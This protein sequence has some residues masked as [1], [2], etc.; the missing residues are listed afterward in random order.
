M[1][2]PP[3][4]RAADVSGGLKV[5]LTLLCVGIFRWYMK[6]QP[7]LAVG[8]GLIAGI[9][10]SQ[11]IPPRKPARYLLLWIAGAAVLAIVMAL[12]PHSGW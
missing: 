1:E 5:A 11:A 8:L 4:P 2:A 9:L 6:S 12:F 7:S 3:K 10:L